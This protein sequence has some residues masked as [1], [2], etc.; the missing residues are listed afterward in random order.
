MTDRK[1]RFGVVSAPQDPEHWP[2]A[3]RRA[4]EWGYSTLLSPDGP[5][6]L[7]PFSSLAQA[8]AVSPIRVGTFVLAA[9]L[10][11]AAIAAWD[12][13]SLSRL[14][15]G[16][17][18]FGVGTGTPQVLDAIRR[19]GMDPGSAGE[20]LARAEEVIDRTRA[21]DTEGQIRVLVAAGGPKAMALAA[22]KADIVTAALGPL[23]S[24]E[25]TQRFYTT[26]RE[27]AGD[28]ADAIELS[29][30]V[31][32]IGDQATPWMEQFMGVDSATMRERDSLTM[33]RGTPQ[34]MADELQRRRDDFGV[35]YVTVNGAFG[36]QFAPVVE[37][38]NGR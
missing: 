12:A 18:E 3:A 30:N 7:S 8:A 1:F 5:Q 9:P 32:V 33:L 29:M 11:P 26:V 36:E 23:V 13:H 14:T 10:R 17:F 19:F 20:R 25:D 4:G 35:S 34:Q 37:L 6:L 31:F 2:E 21:L 15:G 28:R 22:A 27:L 24:R 38:L 16:R